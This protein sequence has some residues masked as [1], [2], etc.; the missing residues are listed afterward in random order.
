MRKQIGGL[1]YIRQNISE[2]NPV[3]EGDIIDYT[4]VHTDLGLLIADGL[5]VVNKDDVGLFFEV[6]VPF[7]K[8]QEE[9]TKYIKAS[10]KHYLMEPGH[11]DSYTVWREIIKANPT[12][13]ERRAIAKALD[14][15]GPFFYVTV[16]VPCEIMFN[17]S[18]DIFSYIKRQ[19]EWKQYADCKLHIRNG[20][21]WSKDVPDVGWCNFFEITVDASYVIERYDVQYL[22]PEEEEND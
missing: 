3:R 14:G 9:L 12:E 5:Y 7:S 16:H 22:L 13:F 8:E 11:S 6:G 2:L 17:S 18:E 19:D 20:N 15:I 21:I 4:S 10:Y 1:S